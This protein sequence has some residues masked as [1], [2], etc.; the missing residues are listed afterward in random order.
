MENL[1]FAGGI[2]KGKSACFS[3]TDGHNA[4]LYIAKSVKEM[5]I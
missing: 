2:Y 1:H 3:S 5:H 4:K